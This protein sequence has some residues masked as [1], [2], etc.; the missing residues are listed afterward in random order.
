MLGDVTQVRINVPM[1]DAE[2]SELDIYD[3]DATL[4]DIVVTVNNFIID[5]TSIQL[6]TDGN[7][8]NA[9]VRIKNR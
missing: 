3:G 1:L 7:P 4:N 6:F 2:F 5:A 8:N 9:Q